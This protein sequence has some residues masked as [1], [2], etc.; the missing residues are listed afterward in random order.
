M[1]RHPRRVARHSYL[2]RPSPEGRVDVLSIRGAEA[3]RSFPSAGGL[4]W[5][6][7]LAEFDGDDLAGNWLAGDVDVLDR[8]LH[9]FD[10][11]AR[12]EVAGGDVVEGAEGEL[13]VIVGV[14]RNQFAGVVDGERQDG[15]VGAADGA[16]NPADGVARAGGWRV[17]VV[18]LGVGVRL[19]KVR[20]WCGF[21]PARRGSIGSFQS[22]ERSQA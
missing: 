16:Q 6:R 17:G 4:A 7:L 13:E 15:G 5:E 21:R 3:P 19:W 11:L 1:A 9:A 18:D 8:G 2:D 12:I 20:R 10:S 14:Q 22:C